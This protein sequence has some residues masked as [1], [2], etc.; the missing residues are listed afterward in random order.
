MLPYISAT[1][2]FREVICQLAILGGTAKV[3]VNDW[4]ECGSRITALAILNFFKENIFKYS[5]SK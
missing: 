4:K 2:A 5:S 1:L 3:K